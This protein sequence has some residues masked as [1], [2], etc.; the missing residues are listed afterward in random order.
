MWKISFSVAAV[1]LL[2]YLVPAFAAMVKS[3]GAGS[4]IWIISIPFM[5]LFLTIRLWGGLWIAAGLS[6][7]G[8]VQFVI[9]AGLVGFLSSLVLSFVLGIGGWTVAITVLCHL[10]AAWVALRQN[11]RASQSV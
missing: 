10:F 3:P 1:E 5:W 2:I 9:A 4:G 7:A 8:G 11:L 6:S